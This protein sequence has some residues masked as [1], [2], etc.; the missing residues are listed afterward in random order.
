MA[1][2]FAIFETYDLLNLYLKKKSRKK[3]RINHL[4][5]H[6]IN[7]ADVKEVSIF[8]CLLACPC[9]SHP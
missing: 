5:F 9:K 1:A 3:G 8:P 2:A 4:D 6:I 7:F